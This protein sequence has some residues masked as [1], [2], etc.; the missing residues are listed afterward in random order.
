MSGAY[1]A[2]MIDGGADAHTVGRDPSGL[3]EMGSCSASAPMPDR[4]D[5]GPRGGTRTAVEPPRD[6]KQGHA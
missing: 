1:A 3:T 2:T 6:A 4:A 5:L